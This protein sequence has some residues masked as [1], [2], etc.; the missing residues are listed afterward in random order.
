L[1]IGRRFLDLRRS[2]TRLDAQSFTRHTTRT[3]V[4]SSLWLRHCCSV[5]ELDLWSGEAWIGGKPGV[6]FF[7]LDAASRVAVRVALRFFHLPYYWARM[8]N[9]TR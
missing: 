6:Y 4:H 9:Q 7:S 5:F 3:H 1:T 2:E 8:K